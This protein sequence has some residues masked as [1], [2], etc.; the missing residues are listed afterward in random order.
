ME[1]ALGIGTAV[2]L[3]ALALELGAELAE[4]VDLA[5]EH[6]DDAAVLV[7][8]G[9]GAGLG[10]VEDRQAAE[11]EGDAAVDELSSHVG[12]AMDDPIHHLGEDLG[13]VTRPTDKTDKTAHTQSPL[14]LLGNVFTFQAGSEYTRGHR[15]RPKGRAISTVSTPGAHESVTNRESYGL[16][17]GKP[18]APLY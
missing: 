18:G 3:V 9:L 10:E 15:T 2:E 1:Q 14:L 12:P 13:L 11:A 16:P 17:M 4:V 7:G 8:H 5:V 6:D